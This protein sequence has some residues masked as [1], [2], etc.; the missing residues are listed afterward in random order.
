MLFIPERIFRFFFKSSDD[1][2]ACKNTQN[3]KS[4][5]GDSGQAHF[6]IQLLF[7]DTVMIYLVYI[8][9]NIFDKIIPKPYNLPN[10]KFEL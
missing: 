3:A 7:K 5:R 8:E 4:L 10:L 9:S 1:N 2:N 6:G